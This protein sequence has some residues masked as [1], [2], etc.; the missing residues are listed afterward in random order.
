MAAAVV[1]QVSLVG[2]AAGRSRVREG[3]GGRLTSQVAAKPLE[4]GDGL[5]SLA[6]RGPPQR[7]S[8]AAADGG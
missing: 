3:N 8:G 7:R 5:E 1:G 4:T 2:I 6:A